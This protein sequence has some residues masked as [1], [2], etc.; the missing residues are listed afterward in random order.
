MK[1]SSSELNKA[2]SLYTQQT[3]ATAQKGKAADAS[4]PKATGRRDEVV[5]SDRARE[6]QIALKAAKTSDDV[7]QGL[8]DELRAK[9]A[10]GTYHVP[11]KDVAK[12]MLQTDKP[13]E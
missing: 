6:I 13:V 10:S 12:A 4:G 7:R 1:V 3:K 5:L 2:M 8:V 9:I 11:A